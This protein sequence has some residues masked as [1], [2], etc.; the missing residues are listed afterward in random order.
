MPDVTVT[1][2]SGVVAAGLGSGPFSPLFRSASGPARAAGVGS[3]AVTGDVALTA[4][5]GV[6]VSGSAT[7]A[8]NLVIALTA[9]SGVGVSGSSGGPADRVIALTASGLSTA[10]GLA[11]S[12]N[13]RVLSVTAATDSRA[14]GGGDIFR[15]RVVEVSASGPAVAAGLG[16][17]GGDRL[18]SGSSSAVAAGTPSLS[19]ATF[20]ASASSSAALAGAGTAVVAIPVSATGSASASGVG[21]SP[22]LTASVSAA[23]AVSAAGSASGVI[24]SATA[25]GRARVGGLASVFA[26]WA[27]GVLPGGDRP[28]G[29][30]RVLA[31]VLAGNNP[32][33]WAVTAS[34]DVIL[35]NGLGPM[36]R[37]FPD[38][39]IVE[40]VG[41]PAPTA[42][43]VATPSGQGALSGTRVAAVRFVDRLGMPG[44]ISPLSAPF[45]LGADGLVTNLYRDT[46]TGKTV[47]ECD[48]PHG[49]T[50]P[51]YVEFSDV[52][53]SADGPRQAT[54]I[55]DVRM[56]VG[57]IGAAESNWSAGGSWSRGS[58]SVL[59]SGLPTTND[60][61]LV[62]RQVL[63]S[64]E[65]TTDALYVDVDSEVLST[66]TAS[67]SLT[68]D[69]LAGREMVPIAPEA[70]EASP[71]R[72][73]PPP[74]DKA[75]LVSHG[76]L[77]FAAG[78]AHYSTGHVS[79]IAG[80]TTAWTVGASWG[81]WAVGRVLKVHGVAGSFEVLSVGAD[82]SF[83]VDAPMPESA[84]YAPY[85]LSPA[86][87]ER[88]TIRYSAPDDPGSWPPWNAIVVHDEDELVGLAS[89]GPY[90]HA[91]AARRTYRVT[92]S[93]DPA[94]SASVTP[95]A[96]RG[97]VTHRCIVRA[98]GATLMLDEAGVWALPDD[99][100]PQPLSGPI[101]NVFSGID[102]PLAV[103]WAADRSLWHG[104]YDPL[105]G[106]AR[107]VVSFVGRSALDTAL[108]L[109]LRTGDWWFEDYPF[110][111]TSSTQAA[112]GGV[113]RAIAG[114]DLRRVAC[115][116]S[117]RASDGS[118]T[119]VSGVSTSASS[120]TIVMSGANF[121]D[122]AGQPIA[123]ENDDGTVQVRMVASNTAT[124]IEVVEP[125]T[126][127]PSSSRFAVGGISWS[128]RGPWLEMA[129]GQEGNPRSIEVVHA[130]APGE[131]AWLRL[132]HDHA[133][134]PR[135]AGYSARDDGVETAEGSPKILLDLG[136]AGPRAGF[137]TKRAEGHADVHAYGDLFVSVAIAGVQSADPA[138]ISR[139]VVQ[140]YRDGG[141]S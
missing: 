54:R 57:G 96:A 108:C 65:G 118:A 12:G 132:Y 48:R 61:R 73:S 90:L 139:V 53:R 107:W 76:G 59:Y 106:V 115:L 58:A 56:L 10:A 60:P 78:S 126:S 19:S 55:D 24:G 63:R 67:S 37:W 83:E 7:T 105:L 101:D 39:E 26:T 46:A 29:P 1:A 128:W 38:D 45:S 15:A 3:V 2:S 92:F 43:I 117:S 35:A 5:S 122:L 6:S 62:R 28:D 124:S 95:T 140:G 77:L 110:V 8:N 68:D 50:S 134:S 109:H 36:V 17:I 23:G 11:S 33:S 4:S 86:P 121:G 20:A 116:W 131:R 69:Q 32:F 89:S 52:S 87:A 41:V 75:C 103:D 111:V 66:T 21:G 97:A 99:G 127:T 42:P 114:V 51:S 119:P 16:S 82:G 9:S 71:L 85:T 30:N 80:L 84:T 34:G 72:N 129:G 79:Y 64:L 13:D 74:Q 133:T 70:L 94:R 138:R 141:R 100:G 91:V 112:I 123:V 81:S 31:R 44:P 104:S 93:G 113:R 98:E 27:G 88:R 102:A 49:I 47:V 137:L 22:P 120:T 18:V 125:W 25:E 136:R 135:A 14:G 130:P 40:E